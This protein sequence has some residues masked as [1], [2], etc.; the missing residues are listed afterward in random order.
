MVHYIF[1]EAQWLSRYSVR[2]RIERI[3][4]VRLTNGSHCVVS[5]RKTIYPLLITSSTKEEEKLSW[6]DVKIVGSL[7]WDIFKSIKTNK[8]RGCRL[9][10]KLYFSPWRYIFNSEDTW[11]LIDGVKGLSPSQQYFTHVGTS[12]RKEEWKTKKAPTSPTRVKQISSCRQAIYDRAIS[13]KA[14]A[15]RAP[16]LNFSGLF[17]NSG[18][19]GWLSIDG[20]PAFKCWIKQIIIASDLFSVHLEGNWP[21][22]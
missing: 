14:A 12:P 9:Q 20:K 6:Q 21:F 17:L 10:F 11:F 4:M 19:W 18:F 5:L 22:I 15:E 13:L 3:A 7:G 2:L 1:S 8:P 16:G